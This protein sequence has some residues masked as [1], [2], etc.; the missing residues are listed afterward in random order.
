MLVG[1]IGLGHV[2]ANVRRLFEGHAEVVEYDVSLDEDYPQER[3]SQCDFAAVCVDT[4]CSE[5]GECRTR[6]VW[7]AVERLPVDRVLL[8][9]TV[10]PGTTD[11]LVRVTRKSVCFAPEYVGESQ[12][13]SP[14]WRNDEPAAVPFVILGGEESVRRWFIEALLPIF[15]P[16]KT[17]F[18]C[19]AIEAEMIKYMENGYFATKLSFVNEFARMCEEFDADWHTVREG[20]L[21]DPRV[22]GD[23]T[24]VFR[25]TP[26]FGGKCLQK[27]LSA[28][29]WAAKSRGYCPRLLE[30]VRASNERF[31]R[32]A[33]HGG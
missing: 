7:N 1:V 23:H 33:G 6:N 4:P 8:K 19:S 3:L 27:D 2:G 32:A 24:A 18:Q 25:E 14:F 29:I 9:S 21:L 22:E 30:E 26:G 17:Y 10:S 15:G 13:F 20:W 31:R 16:S 11:E 5:S 12:Y 28:I